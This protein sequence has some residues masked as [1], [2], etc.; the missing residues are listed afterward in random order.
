MPTIELF[1]LQAIWFI[2]P[3]YVGN[4]AP[5]FVTWIPRSDMPVDFGLRWRTKRI[6]GDHKTWRGI[7]VGVMI[8]GLVAAV[9][10]RPLTQGI[11]L[12]AGNFFGDLVGAFVKRQ[13]D[14]QPG[15]KKLLI[16]AVPSQIFAIAAAYAFGFL[17]ISWAQSLLL[18]IGIVPV[19]I[20]A[21]WLWYK[22]RLKSVPW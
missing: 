21:N 2:L 16:D 19:H 3:A 17:T 18:I 4:V 12:A 8:G 5:I 6:F 13:S 9:Q 11:I 20:A 1:V 15:E 10:G 14:V 22:L 7:V